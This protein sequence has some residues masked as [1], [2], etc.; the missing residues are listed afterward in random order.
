MSLQPI[1]WS[2]TKVYE[3]TATSTLTVNATVTDLLYKRATALPTS[4]S[5][6][7]PS[8]ATAC[9]NSSQ[10]AS[11]CSCMG[12]TARTITLNATV[13]DSAQLPVGQG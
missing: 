13:S 1:S 7:I 11:A 4:M 8:Y 6:G 12:V 9:S 2:L 10:Y 3:S 5:N